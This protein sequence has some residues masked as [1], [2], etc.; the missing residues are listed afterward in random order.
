MLVTAATVFNRSIIIV[1]SYLDRCGH[2]CVSVTDKLSV[3]STIIARMHSYASACS[4]ASQCTHI[5]P[6]AMMNEG[7]NQ[8]R[9]KDRRLHAF[10]LHF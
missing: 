9:H 5:Y 1:D 6:Q 7:E 2:I 10:A 8:W 3:V 4:Q